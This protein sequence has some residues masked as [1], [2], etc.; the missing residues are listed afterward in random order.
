V[1][2]FVIK[3]KMSEFRLKVWGKIAELQAFFVSLRV[4]LG[5]YIHRF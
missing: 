1:T 4:F 5:Y 3:V 2:A